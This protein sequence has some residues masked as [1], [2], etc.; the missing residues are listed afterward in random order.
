[1]IS[2]QS[3][4]KRYGGLVAVNDVSFSVDKGEVI[5]FLGPNGAGKTTCMRMLTGFLPPTEGTAVIAGHDIFLDPIVARRSVGYL[6]ESPPL[7]PE[8]T[9][10]AVEH[11]FEQIQQRQNP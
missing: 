8:M 6:P 1:M 2:I 5:G 4:S 3:V 7:Y 11:V 10:Q 9:N